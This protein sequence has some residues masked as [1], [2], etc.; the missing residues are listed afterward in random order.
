M[1]KYL[2]DKQAYDAALGAAKYD[3]RFGSLLRPFTGSDLENEPGYQFVLEEGEEAINRAALGRGSFDS[4]ATLKA[5]LRYGQ[6]YA[7]TKYTDA[8]NRDAAEKQRIYNMLAGIAGTGQ[9]AT[10]QVAQAGGQSASNIAN[11][12]SSQG[13]ARAAGIVGSSNAWTNALN[14]GI[15]A[16][17]NTKMLEYLKQIPSGTPTIPNFSWAG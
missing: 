6:D 10:G 16:W 17:Q 2:A 12:L 1:A 4:G 7:G 9:T 5:L 14:Q 13:D 3:P 15:G 11:L 8:F